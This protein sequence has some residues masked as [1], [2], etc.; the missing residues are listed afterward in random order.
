MVMMKRALLLAGLVSIGADAKK[1]T[2]A[3]SFDGNHPGDGDANS[4]KPNL[5]MLY[6]DDMGYG[7]I[8]YNN[9]ELSK[10]S[11]HLNKL[12]NGG[13]ILDQFYTSPTCTASRASLLTGRYPARLGLQ[14][15][16][17]HSTEPRGV[18]L[19]EVMLPQ[20]LSEAGYK[21]VAFGK[22]HLGF[23]Q[24]QYLP[25]RRGFDDFYGIL[26]GGGDHFAH[27]S[28]GSFEMRGPEYK[29]TK[30]LYTGYNLVHND[31]PVPDEEVE[32][33]HSTD[34]YTGKALEF[35]DA[36]AAA[37][38]DPKTEAQPWFM[39]LAYQAIHSPMQTVSNEDSSCNSIQRKTKDRA[40]ASM[41]KK[42]CGMLEMVDDSAH[43]L[44]SALKAGDMWDNTLMVFLSDNGGIIRHGSS[45]SPLRGEKGEYYEGGI[46]VPGFFSGGFVEREL[47][48]TGTEPYTSKAL[49]HVTD[50]HATMLK[51]AGVHADP[52]EIDGVD[53]WD[54]IVEA[55][56]SARG[57][58]LHNINSDLF[59]NAGA[60]RHGDYKLIV[61]SRVSESEIY[62][63][64]QSMLQD[65]DWDMSELSQ[66][67][68]QKLLRTPGQYCLYN[69]VK[70][71]SEDESGDC[72]D[73][74]GCTNL[75]YN[76][77]FAAKRDEML[78]LWA[79]YVA[80]V[81]SS[82]EEWV[83]DGPLADPA[84]FGGY[85][86]PW[87]DES[88]IPYAIYALADETHHLT[89]AQHPGQK[90]EQEKVDMSEA[91]GSDGQ[92]AAGAKALK[93]E[94]DITE[95]E[96]RRRLESSAGAASAGVM[97]SAICLVG[98]VVAG[99]LG[100]V[101]TTRRQ[102]QRRRGLF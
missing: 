89:L 16:V 77:D 9:Q 88:G 96:E 101:A 11:R 12:A 32:G 10:A 4:T 61:E 65:S 46:R 81:P 40:F 48:R 41:R 18:P 97:Q 19:E 80:D 36:A 72:A 3:A 76:E 84:H 92:L 100:T 2:S 13:I 23:H 28:T 83:D 87:R 62:S 45:N 49:F 8:G 5:L 37:I 60:L 15:S 78:A 59:G 27:L 6:V 38:R 90:G 55:K 50:I 51:V 47:L 7:D 85:W 82:T 21:T 53:Q 14:D 98:G 39:Y 102:E 43:K 35:L 20:K 57:S 54:A 99:V 75:Y 56:D 26:T 34:I 30:Y 17:I 24:A 71:P 1:A 44:V 33:M 67:I 69:V 25:H 42:L 79:D 91:L 31:E 52:G 86:T 95:D 63:Y 73:F 68:H 74:E 64:G 22:W 70:N 94:G 93:G 66:V 58:I 29:S